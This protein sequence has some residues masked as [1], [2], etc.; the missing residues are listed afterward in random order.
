MFS[1]LRIARLQG[2]LLTSIDLRMGVYNLSSWSSRQSKPSHEP[3]IE[4]LII[5]F[6]QL[7]YSLQNEKSRRLGTGFVPGINFQVA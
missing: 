4:P 7:P 1:F 5:N 6:L 2:D 3:Y